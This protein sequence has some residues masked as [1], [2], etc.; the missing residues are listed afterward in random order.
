LIKSKTPYRI[1]WSVIN[2]D[3]FEKVEEVTI[4]KLDSEG[5]PIRTTFQ[6]IAVDTVI[7]GYGLTPS[8]EFFRL[9]DVE[10]YYSK[11]EGI[12]LPKRNEFL[13]TS[14]QGIYAIGDCAGIGGANLAMLEGKIAAI[15]IATQS[16]HTH[17][18]TMNTTFKQTKKHLKREQNF[19]QMMGDIFALPRG[20]FS[21]AQP[22]TI[23][24]RCEQIS[25]A[26]VKEAIAF[27][28]QSVTDIKTITR[29]GMG[30]CQGRTCGSILSQILARE[31]MCDPA[32]CQYLNIRPPIHPIPVEIVEEKTTEV[33][34]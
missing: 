3:G 26:E 19:A 21:L 17:L 23:I 32:D 10:M 11:A 9:L 6:K 27:G 1:G 30:N 7:V 33:L 22:G 15:D 4:A 14:A 18:S 34:P 8:T 5:Y 28:A 29:S 12:F 16:G 20:L 24:C 2:A 25:L 13:Q 31:V